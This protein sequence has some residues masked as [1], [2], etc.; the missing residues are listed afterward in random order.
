MIARKEKPHYLKRLRL[1]VDRRLCYSCGACVAVCPQNSIFLT[2]LH[3]TVDDVACT[4]CGR[5]VLICP[6]R[7]LSLRQ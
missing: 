1:E 7:A 6:A 4:G 3:L 2:N 5:C